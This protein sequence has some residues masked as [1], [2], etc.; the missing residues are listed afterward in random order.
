[1]TTT[2]IISS[3]KPNNNDVLVETLHVQKDGSYVALPYPTLLHEG[4]S[5]VVHV[6]GFNRIEVREVPKTDQLTLPLIVAAP[7]MVLTA[8]QECAPHGVK[9]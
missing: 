3:P 6:H 7:G 2:V 5:T 8:V 4:Q 1:M 9:A